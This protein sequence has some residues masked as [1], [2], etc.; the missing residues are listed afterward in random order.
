MSSLG[1][2]KDEEWKNTQK[3]NEMI[4]ENRDQE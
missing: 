1:T 4:E 3:K 2:K